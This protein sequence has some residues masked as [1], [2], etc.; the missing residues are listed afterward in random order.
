[1]QF[2]FTD[3]NIFAINFFAIKILNNNISNIN[4]FNVSIFDVSIFGV[5]IFN[6]NIFDV[7][8]PLIFLS[9]LFSAQEIGRGNFL[10]MCV[11]WG[12]KKW[13]SQQKHFLEKRRRKIPQSCPTKNFT[14]KFLNER[15]IRS[16]F[17]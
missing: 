10:L 12:G 5:N 15:K 1:M 13:F 11:K 6:I 8:P 7:I 14:K 2:D 9:Q 16:L 3:G 17:S 4:I